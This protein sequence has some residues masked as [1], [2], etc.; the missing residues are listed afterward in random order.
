METEMNL[1]NI[2]LG[3]SILEPSSI[4]GIS[5]YIPNEDVFIQHRAKKL[6][7]IIRTRQKEDKPINT[8]AVSASLTSNDIDCG[9]DAMYIVDCTTTATSQSSIID[10]L[11][12]AKKIESLARNNSSNVYS[13]IQEAH[14]N[15]GQILELKPDDKF[16]IGSELTLAI[17]SI[18]DKESLLLK[19]GYDSLDC[20]MVNIVRSHSQGLHR[21]LSR[22]LFQG[23][24]GLR[25]FRR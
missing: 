19:T 25:I 14:K 10:E 17:N 21:P 4:D 20:C 24:R 2:I 3:Q 5:Q 6:W 7:E 15:L 23:H 11:L 9:V 13:T 18:T 1:E 8:M 16:S 12:H 22:L